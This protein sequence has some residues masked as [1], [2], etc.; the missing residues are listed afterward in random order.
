MHQHHNLFLHNKQMGLMP[1]HL[2]TDVYFKHPAMII[3]DVIINIIVPV[4]SEIIFPAWGGLCLLSPCSIAAAG[5][6]VCASLEA[7]SLCPDGLSRLSLPESL[8]AVL[9]QRGCSVQCALAAG[10]CLSV[11]WYTLLG[12]RAPHCS[13][14]A[15][16]VGRK[17]IYPEES[18]PWPGSWLQMQ[19]AGRLVC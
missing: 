12:A 11:L 2:L 6:V 4:P 3:G 15:D 9:C 1:L 7:L 13:F 10:S 19:A 8:S 14:S 5:F 17:L 18:T 16:T